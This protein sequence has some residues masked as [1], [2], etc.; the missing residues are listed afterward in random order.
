MRSSIKIPLETVLRRKVGFLLSE[1]AI[2]QQGCGLEES[3][4]ERFRFTGTALIIGAMHCDHIHKTWRP[5]TPFWECHLRGRSFANCGR[6]K[7]TPVIW[8]DSFPSSGDVCH[9]TI[10]ASCDLVPYRGESL[11]DHHLLHF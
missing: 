3:W 5:I 7:K 11:L 1:G 6:V 9:A 2:W 8:V 4:H 10:H